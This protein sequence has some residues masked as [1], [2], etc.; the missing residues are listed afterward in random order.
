MLLHLKEHYK[1]AH[2]IFD[3]FIKIQVFNNFI[4]FKS[5]ISFPIILSGQ[6]YYLLMKHVNSLK[7]SS[8]EINV[9]NVESKCLE[10]LF[11]SSLLFRERFFHLCNKIKQVKKKQEKTPKT[12]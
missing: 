7:S 5:Y 9:R 8:S 2:Y 10:L 3:H 6:I 11:F 12:I 4:I 1:C